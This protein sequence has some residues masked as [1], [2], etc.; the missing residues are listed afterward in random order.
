MAIPLSQP[1]IIVKNK[2]KVI[3]R[4]KG[5]ENWGEVIVFSKSANNRHIKSMTNSSKIYVNEIFKQN[6]KLKSQ[7]L[8]TKL[9]KKLIKEYKNRCNKELIEVN[10][11][12]KNSY[13]KN[14]IMN[15]NNMKNSIPNCNNNFIYN[16]NL[17]SI[18]YNTNQ[19][20]NNNN[21]LKEY[22]DNNNH[23]NYLNNC[24]I[25]KINLNQC[26]NKYQLTSNSLN[27]T[28]ELKLDQYRKYLLAKYNRKYKYIS[29]KLSFRIFI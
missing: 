26:N 7:R 12:I 5:K 28:N 17:E 19:M 18:I 14:N 2:K 29:F 27:Q 8:I 21:Y 11:H 16:K 1:S 9:K 10:N 3:S 15:S 24:T 20:N 22:T 4:E 25:P 6:W 23:I 13:F